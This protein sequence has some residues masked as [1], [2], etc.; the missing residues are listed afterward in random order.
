MLTRMFG[1]MLLAVS[2]IGMLQFGTT[3]SR[4]LLPLYLSLLP[5]TVWEEP[6]QPAP[7]QLLLG[8]MLP[9]NEAEMV[10]SNHSICVLPLDMRNG[11][12]KSEDSNRLSIL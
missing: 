6:A 1:R 8:N 9:S 10:I 2:K 7:R 11:F 5:S 4:V 3:L 12:G